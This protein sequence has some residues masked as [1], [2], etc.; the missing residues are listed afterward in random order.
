MIN[1]VTQKK[2]DRRGHH[3]EKWSTKIPAYG[4]F[5]IN[6]KSSKK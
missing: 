3:V 5:E 4:I 6:W 1:F 2:F